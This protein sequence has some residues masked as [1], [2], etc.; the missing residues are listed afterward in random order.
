MKLRIGD[1][2]E[3]QTNKI[4]TRY[5]KLKE[6]LEEHIY[7]YYTLDNA[8][9]SDYAYDTLYTELLNIEKMYPNWITEDSPSQRVGGPMLDGFEKVEHLNPMLSLQR[10]H[11][12]KEILAFDKRVKRRLS[13]DPAID[14]YFCKK[15]IVDILHSLEID[16]LHRILV[17]RFQA[18]LKRNVKLYKGQDAKNIND[19][20]KLLCEPKKVA[21]I[22]KL[23]T[24]KPKTQC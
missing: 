21:E 22:N 7:H 6:E 15:R 5:D 17:I 3:K 18:A 8:K 16:F 11:S 4:R 19:M 13:K 23:L 1:N 2:L 12:V 14:E 10:S 20:Y 24:K 9:I